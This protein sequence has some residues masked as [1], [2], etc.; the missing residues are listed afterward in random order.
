MADEED[1]SMDPTAKYKKNYKKEQK[2]NNLMLRH[3]VGQEFEQSKKVKTK[4]V[5]KSDSEASDSND[6]E[7]KDVVDRINEYREKMLK[8]PQI[9]VIEAA[10]EDQQLVLA[11][12]F[13]EKHKSNAKRVGR[14]KAKRKKSKKKQRQLSQ[15]ADELEKHL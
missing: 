13:K 1:E 6:E 9:K 3:T 14:H 10:D 15:L 11:E 8:I 7:H 12:K 2:L 4:K 5:L